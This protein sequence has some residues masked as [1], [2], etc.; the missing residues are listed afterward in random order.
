[1]LMVLVGFPLCDTH[2]ILVMSGFALL[3]VILVE[4]YCFLFLNI[5]ASVLR[6]IVGLGVEGLSRGVMPRFCLV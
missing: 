3:F 4:Y 6:D 1:M 5:I 2:V